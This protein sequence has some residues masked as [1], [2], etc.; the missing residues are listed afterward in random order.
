MTLTRAS[1]RETIPEFAAGLG[2]LIRGATGGTAGSPAPR[3]ADRT[4]LTAVYE[5]HLEYGSANMS[6]GAGAS[7]M[8]DPV[9][10]GPTLFSALTDQLG[11]KLQKSKSVPVD[12]IVI[13]H[14]DPVP[15]E[16]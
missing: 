16:N 5:F 6:A 3:V 7:G 13:D 14:A 4:G 2:F 8:D 15:T 10:S 12:V 11:L 9:L 1:Y